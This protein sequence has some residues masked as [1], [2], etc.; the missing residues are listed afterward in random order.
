MERKDIMLLAGI[1]AIET[2]LGSIKEQ[3]FGK[4]ASDIIDVEIERK[5][6][7]NDSTKNTNG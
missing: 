1:K 2:F 3:I 4:D 7:K 5:R 6:G